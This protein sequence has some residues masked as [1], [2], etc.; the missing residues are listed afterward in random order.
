[1]DKVTSNSIVSIVGKNGGLFA[2]DSF[3]MRKQM[4]MEEFQMEIDANY[5]DLTL[6][7]IGR[8]IHLREY[9]CIPKIST[10]MTLVKAHQL[11]QTRISP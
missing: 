8:R 7:F 4:K 9:D 2:F 3:T 5:N 6:R 1:M 11:T 10:I